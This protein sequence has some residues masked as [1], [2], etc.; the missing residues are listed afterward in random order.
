MAMV[1]HDGSLLTSGQIKDEKH[2]PAVAT[3]HSCLVF[4][5]GDAKMA[6]MSDGTR[7]LQSIE[8]GDPK[9]GEELL[10]G[11]SRRGHVSHEEVSPDY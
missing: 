2:L 10:P 6:R 11:P 3:R 9:A 4:F 5:K 7:V 8:H 1:Y